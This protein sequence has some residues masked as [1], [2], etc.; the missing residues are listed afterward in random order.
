MK[1][2]RY[3]MNALNV[4]INI[5]KTI[6]IH[7]KENDVKVFKLWLSVKLRINKHIVS[8][9]PLLPP[10]LLLFERIIVTITLDSRR[11]NGCDSPR[12]IRYFRH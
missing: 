10:L 3:S 9:L 1:A 5:L 7:K 4:S 8:L 11:Q 12:N 6:K 2:R